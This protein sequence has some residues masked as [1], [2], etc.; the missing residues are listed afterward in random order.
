MKVKNYA[1]FIGLLF[2][3]SA[4]AQVGIGTGTPDASAQ[5]E[6]L[7]VSKGL[8][9]P[10][11][12]VVQR[13]GIND[14][15]N[16]L[17]I[18]QTNASPGFYFYSNGQW[19]KLVNNSD[20]NSVVAG[21]NGNSILSGN[22]V[23][24][25][26]IGM[27][28][29]FYLDLTSTTL[30]GPKVSGNW[31]SSGIILTG[32]GD[33]KLSF[34]SNYNLGIK[35]G[36]IVSLSDLNQSLS[37]VGTVLSISG[38]RNSRVD[39]AGLLGSGGGTGGI[40]AV[41]HDAT[42]IGNG[43][44]ASP[45]GLSTTGVTGG[46]SVTSVSV[47]PTNGFT[48]TVV[49]A[50][51]TPGITFGTSITGILK[52]EAGALKAAST[53]GTGDVVLSEGPTINNP[54]LTG[55]V[56]GNITGTASNV[57][58]TVAIAN[59]G[60]GANNA[61]GAKVNLGLGLVNN[62]SDAAKP[63]STATQLA[64]DLKED[65]VNKIIDGTFSANSDTNYPSEKAT[66]TYVDNKVNAAVVAGGG[67]VDAT[68][69]V[70]GK[71]QLS[72][73]LGG[74]ASAPT[75]PGLALKEPLITNLPAVKG[76][77]GMTSYTAGNFISALNATTLQQRTPFQVKVDL[78]LD[79][80]SNVSDLLKPI[81]TATQAALNTKIDLT[82]KAAVN[83]VATLDGSGKIPLTQIPALSF[84]S[85]DVLNDEPSMLALAGAVV[86][87][88][89][90]RTDVSKSFVLG[91]TPA[92]TLANW[93]EILTPT[94]TAVQ[95]VNGVA[96]PYVTLS[97][98]DLG[99]PN[100]DNTSD[101]AKPVSTLTQNALNLKQDISNISNDITT[102]GGSITKYPSVKAIKNY[103]D[104][105]V[106][107]GTS[108]DATTT[109]K[110]IVKLA[111]DLGGTAL[112]PTV[113]G[114]A[115]K[116]DKANKSTD[117][118]LDATSNIK[119]PT[120][121]AVKTYVDS[122]AGSVD[123][124][125]TVKGSVMLSGD[126]GGTANA[127]VVIAVGGATASAVK[128]GVDLANAAT[129]Q[130]ILGTI[131]KR[132]GL[133]NIE[134]GAVTGNLNG[135]ATTATSAGSVTGTVMVPNGGTGITSYIPG[136]FINALDATTLQQRTPAEVTSALGLNNVNNTSDAAKPV[137][138]ATGSALALK[139]DK[140]NK[141][142]DGTFAA[143]SDNNY[144]SEKATRTYVDNKVAAAV[145]AGGGVPDATKTISGKIM[146]AGDLD[147]V[148]SA[149]TV[150]GLAL[151]EPIITNLS[152]D[153][154]GT[155][156]TSYTAGNFISAFNATTLQQRTPAQ[157]KVDLAL[158]NV[159]NLSDAAKPVSTA[160][161]TELNK[162]I[163]LTEKAAV[164]GVATL[165]GSGKIPVGQIPALSFG[166]VDVLNSEAAM[167]ALT[168]AVVGSTVI[169]TDVSK[170][171]VL[172]A[173]P[174]STLA[175]WKE[176]LSPTSTAVQTVNGVAGPNVTLTKTDLSLANVENTSDANKPV[177]T[178]TAT[179]LTAKED[180]SN[181][182]LDVNT[183][184][185]SDTKYPSVKAIKTYVD[186]VSAAGSPDATTTGKGVVKL[187]G[188]LGGT[189]PLPTVLFVGG[190]AATAVNAGVILANNATAVN[191]PN[192]IVKRDVSGN[193]AA[194]TITGN[195]V[196][197]ASTAT[198]ISGTVG[199]ANGGTGLNSLTAGSYLYA[200]T[201]TSIGQKTPTQLKTD[202]A[203][204]NVDNTSDAAKPVST[205]TQTAL[206]LKQDIANISNNITA[207]AISTTKYPSVKAIK[208]YA[209][210]MVSGGGSPATTTAKGIVML[211]GDLSNTADAP[212]VATVGGSTAA[213][214]NTATV[215]VSSATNTATAGTIVKR[216][217]S[218]N[219]SANFNGPLTGNVTGN[220]TGNAATV[221]TNAN[222]TGD[223]TSVGN[224]TTIGA[225]KV[226]Y[227]KM[228]VMTTNKLLGSGAS[229]TAVSEVTLGTGLSF[230]GTTLNATA[231]GSG[232][233]SSVSA[234]GSN[235]INVS[236]ATAT[237]TPAIT[238]SLGAIT[239]SSIN[240]TGSVT[241]SNVSGS[242]TGDQTIAL[243][244]DVT[245]TGT[246][247]FAA[248]IGANK[249]TY[250]KMQAMTANKL[251]GSGLAGTT[252]SEII[253]GTGLSFTGNTLNAAAG[254]A[255]AT[256]LGYTPTATDGALTSSSGTGTT[257]T[258]ATNALAGLMPATDKAKL[259]KIADITV[260]DAN[261]VLTV[262]AAGTAATW[263]TA[264]AGGGGGTLQSYHPSG[265]YSASAI[266]TVTATGPGVT[267]TQSD[268]PVAGTPNRFT[269][270]IPLGVVLIKAKFNLQ[271][272]VFGL[273][274]TVNA[275][276]VYYDI[277][278]VNIIDA[279]DFSEYPMPIFTLIQRPAAVPYGYL[280]LGVA[281]TPNGISVESF[282]NKTITIKPTQG[283]AVKIYTMI[284]SF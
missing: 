8:L 38:P 12:S 137:S 208:D 170:S 26:G 1:M 223:V 226:T 183:D 95:S 99:L 157:V 32:S 267:V 77:T 217:A 219:I 222:L 69:T 116:E 59:G 20:L 274:T 151:K 228:Q 2:V 158:D 203:L 220:V 42:L 127:P 277:N 124:T 88:T 71:I 149:P 53:T 205:A 15:A 193:F 244:G 30:F 160:T 229:G 192:T 52:G 46:G 147:G 27:D 107:G 145:V 252:V 280:T 23:P 241:A 221:T 250:A 235:G 39:F 204:N 61:T 14:P 67:V 283:S 190:S 57:T 282:S 234:T 253:L 138:T 83:G 181:K 196:G 84:G 260:P 264:A 101:A 134:V 129:T 153:R 269:I 238:L 40:S 60:T 186:A 168:G 131:V 18:Y 247:S 10:R 143:N 271:N 44:F 184:A 98:T 72:G 165:D 180:I 240:T 200:A 209:D 189:A 258:G 257:I 185:S 155:G 197:N 6:I 227:A 21:T 118:L 110:G 96:G 47:V 63:V 156:M 167:L 144:P 130:N 81:S 100:V 162:K 89:V 104:A 272:P 248:T 43:T 41:Q 108:P 265:T 11:M 182:S 113:P 231:G 169:R 284:L 195:L 263:V 175:N 79:N 17:L 123:A 76:G 25:A 45:L 218:G 255:G 142:I 171:F 133:G 70:I 232:T 122:K 93:K 242:N 106:S 64:L 177:S 85:V 159:S 31:P 278:D 114:L 65:K 80:V 62:T 126:L 187:A 48:G 56:Q 103:T 19:Q 194:G 7:S 236:V 3:L 74:V 78:G 225:N 148:A 178:A 91:A 22:S 237:T 86:G 191:T 245:G 166:S 97:K 28:G 233:V 279:S 92:S 276:I 213:A 202:L 136:N 188:D 266:I 4:K 140:A 174:A 198:S 224:A 34:D 117:V 87:S 120:V 259:D 109:G 207:D 29:D 164:N 75:V 36:N 146:L 243:T 9:I 111:G 66:K 154:G 5:L 281:G 115:F 262:N 239:P 55:M 37:L 128:T 268:G 54:I 201:T 152:A 215:A 121:N 210:A 179:A 199:V 172:G 119:Y 230:T 35:G 173:T 16:G 270:T 135:N 68:T 163:N 273:A 251:L 13:N 73:D 150:P 254:G 216:D 141:S 49:N 212:M 105:L 139:E 256:N 58:G 246:G 94:G 51:T 132:D 275:P 50:T 176:I 24:S 161:Q 261:K 214:I 211:A 112:V 33:L 82:E 90:I 249:V 125:T 102:D 206:N